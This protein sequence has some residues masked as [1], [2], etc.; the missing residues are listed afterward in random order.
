MTT[1]LD[2]LQKHWKYPSFRGKQLEI[3]Q[4][5]LAGKDTLAL[6]PTGGGKSITF[7]V[8][9]LAQ[10]GFCLVIS[11]LISLMN[12]QVSRLN[13]LN[14][15]A[16]SLS[17]KLDF[18]EQLRILD[19]AV[20]GAYKFLYISPERLQSELFLSKIH[21]F[22]I[23]LIAVDEAH[24]ISEWGHDFRPSYRKIAAIRQRLPKV[25]I[26]ALTATA[27]PV[28]IDDIC[29][30]LQ[31]KKN[32]QI[33]KDS[34]ERKNLTYT[35]AKI[36]D[37]ITALERLYNK[38]KSPS[39]IYVR[40][41][42]LCN[43][44]SEQ[45]NYLG[46]STTIYNAGL[47]L[48]EREANFKKWRANQA[49]IMIATNAFGM[50]I[51]KADVRWVIHYNIPES[52]E[53]YFQEAGR[54]GRD[55][56]TANALLLYNEADIGLVKNQ[57]L[58][59]MPSIDFIKLVYKKL[60]NEYQIAYN[61]RN[62]L[63]QDF[64][65]YSFYEKY[66]FKKNITYNALQ[67]LHREGIIGLSENFGNQSSI[68]FNVNVD[69]LLLYIERTKKLATLI[70]YLLRNSGGAFEAFVRI[71][72]YIIARQLAIS[73]EA[74]IEQLQVLEA[75]NILIYNN[76][77]TDFSISFLHIREDDR[78]INRIK[79]NIQ[80]LQKQK[81]EK[82]TAML[83]FVQQ[84]TQCSNRY[85][86]AYFGEH[87]QENCKKC[88]ICKKTKN[89]SNQEYKS[90]ASS[91]KSILTQPKTSIELINTLHNHEEKLILKTIQLLIE[92]GEI[93]LNKYNQYFI[94]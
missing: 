9:A 67:I 2:I 91:I 50:G 54:A 12:D 68:Q 71:N 38:D 46:F 33:I 41:R 27:T 86:L 8:A 73:K 34:F 6:L 11:P 49:Q 79:K 70:K 43:E 85:L 7:Q 40:S 10:D 18:N 14:I 64:D 24:C 93:G 19:N 87:K 13:S 76:T 48:E 52:I 29:E 5:I 39:I 22:N 36:N 4:S 60:C 61:E 56:N 3:I 83:D 90:I 92:Q 30:Q 23:N 81:Q 75:E 20:Y 45:L 59:N 31:F 32:T 53:S 28:V 47:S 15:K 62:E 57:F 66:K 16:I 58:D 84:K 65:F 17:G 21:E 69:E 25:P 55:G 94:N 26:L 82:V 44:I 89:T 37:K 77:N 78:T 80:S 72:E 74:V 35:V 42:F 63:M 1:P 51:D 88:T